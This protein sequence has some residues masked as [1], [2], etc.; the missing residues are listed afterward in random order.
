MAAL[1]NSQCGEKAS[2]TSAEFLEATQW[3]RKEIYILDASE[4][5]S[6]DRNMHQT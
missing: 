4:V 1:A 5:E 6:Y 3:N 2:L